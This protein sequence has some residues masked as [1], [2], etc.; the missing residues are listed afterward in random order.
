MRDYIQRVATISAFQM[1]YSEDTHSY[2]TYTHLPKSIEKE[3]IL[4]VKRKPIL[5]GKF[6]W[7]LRSV[8]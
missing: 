3:T 6:S 2:A 1:H 4:I 5:L 7:A 8:Q